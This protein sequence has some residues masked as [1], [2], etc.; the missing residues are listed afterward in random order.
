MRVF[1]AL[2]LSNFQL[3]VRFAVATGIDQFSVMRRVGTER[4]RLSSIRTS[5]VGGAISHL[6]GTLFCG[7]E[8]AIPISRAYSR[9]RKRK[10]RFTH[11]RKGANPS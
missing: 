9:S 7:F 11:L 2:A 1:Y 6:H 3:P 5:W 8:L 10:L 4:Q